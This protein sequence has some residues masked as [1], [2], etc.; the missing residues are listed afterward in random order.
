MNPKWPFCSLSLPPSLGILNPFPLLNHP[1]NLTCVACLPHTLGYTNSTPFI[2]SKASFCSS[3]TKHLTS[4]P[5]YISL[6][7]GF[8]FFPLGTIFFFYAVDKLDNLS[9]MN[10]VPAST[11]RARVR[12]WPGKSTPT[13]FLIRPVGRG[14]KPFPG[15]IHYLVVRT[16]VKIF[17]SHWNG[18][19]INY[20][21]AC[22]YERNQSCTFSHL[23]FI[24]IVY[25]FAF[26]CIS[27]LVALLSVC[28]HVNV[29]FCV[30]AFE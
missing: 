15:Q 20:F 5:T 28:W 12:L 6:A 19:I 30:G 7:T 29:H 22:L 18:K 17:V 13:T 27:V 10:I 25:A 2:D 9:M 3:V 23:F 8:S 21:I 26:S 24:M 16:C 1:P 4:Y 11:M 14:R